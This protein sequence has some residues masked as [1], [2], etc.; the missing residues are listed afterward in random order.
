MGTLVSI[1][2]VPTANAPLKSAEE[3]RA[4]PG[5]GLE[6]D[7][8]FSSQGTYS[9]R[10]SPSREVTLI[11]MEAIEAV[12]SEAGIK[13]DAGESRRNL[14]T[15]NVALNHLVGRE[16][17]VGTVR[18]RGI[19]LCEPCMHLEGLTRKGVMAALIHRGGLRAQILS[20]G[21]LHVGDAIAGAVET[22]EANK[23][24]IRRY[25][26]EM[27]NLWNFA[28]ADELL[29]PEIEFRGSLGVATKGRD[30]FRGYMRLVRN[31]FPDF[32][33]KIDQLVAEGDTVV[34]RLTYRGTHRGEVFGLAPTG[35]EIMYS[36][37]AIF[38]IAE[39]KIAEGWVLGDRLG[40][41]Q[42][43]GAQSVPA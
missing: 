20:A 2:I 35:K 14:V 9:D 25:Y 13:F 43:L 26:E 37:A 32:H 1:Y 17:M 27:W 42:Q 28:V 31:S 8:Y 29:A 18:L 21:V 3:V 24:L 5:K 38:R 10:P 6:G 23:K 12:E 7:R 15:R 36:G 30:A 19:R 39:G 11:E 22:A 40:L 33:N 16:F 41:L 4:V 34:A